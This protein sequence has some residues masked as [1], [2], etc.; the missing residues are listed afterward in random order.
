[1]KVKNKNSYYFLIAL[2]FGYNIN[3]KMLCSKT[4]K[5][6]LFFNK[7]PFEQLVFKN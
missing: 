5:G 6:N 1:M 4:K 3:L 2:F 7:L